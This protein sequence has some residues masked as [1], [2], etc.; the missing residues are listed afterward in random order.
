[1]QGQKPVTRGL[2]DPTATA[3]RPFPL[4]IR[5]ATLD[6]QTSA[7]LGGNHPE[8]GVEMQS[9]PGSDL[10]EGM[11]EGQNAAYTFLLHEFGELSVGKK[12][13]PG[14]NGLALTISKGNFWQLL[15][16]THLHQLCPLHSCTARAAGTCLSRFE[17]RTE[18]QVQQACPAG[19]AQRL[20]KQQMLPFKQLRAAPG[21]A[22][23]AEIRRLPSAAV[24]H[25]VPRRG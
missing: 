2:K 13:S 25:A 14:H 15:L 16:L 12:S 23:E 9:G 6:L 17:Q 7:G 3:G 10:E 20:S 8:P 19:G 11:K 21:S 5:V 1:M 18:V 4:R 22:G 24:S